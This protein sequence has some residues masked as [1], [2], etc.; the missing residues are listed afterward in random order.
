M[1]NLIKCPTC[2]KE[3]SDETEYCHNCYEPI[4]E[5]ENPND[6]LIAYIYNGKTLNTPLYHDDISKIEHLKMADKIEVYDEEYKLQYIS[7]S[8]NDNVINVYLD[9]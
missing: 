6:I 5:K 4:K 7:V 1:G 8:A 2:K 9:K 3:I